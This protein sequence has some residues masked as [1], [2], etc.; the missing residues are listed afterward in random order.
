MFVAVDIGNT[1]IEFVVFYNNLIKDKFFVSSKDINLENIKHKL[2]EL[3]IDGK[4]IMFMI[5]SVVPEATTI[6]NVFLQKQ[7]GSQTYILSYKDFQDTLTTQTI[8]LEHVGLDILCKSLWSFYNCKESIIIDVGTASVVQYTCKN[9]LECVAISIGLGSIYG[10]LHSGTALLPSLSV[11]TSNKLLGGNTNDAIAGGV[12]YG[13]I[14]MIQAFIKQSMLETGCKNIYLT[15]GLSY[16]IKDSFTD[17]VV[18][19]QNL[20]VEGIKKLY[21]EKYS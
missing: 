12:Y 17:I 20:I 14:G 9:K 3:E 19:N 18:H 8:N 5:S 7:C 21:N 11:A 2:Q 4:N 16:I 13:Y 6:L 10:F 1:T 15:G